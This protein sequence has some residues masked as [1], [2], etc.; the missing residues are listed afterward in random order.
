AAA[1]AE[2]PAA[3]EAN[4]YYSEARDRTDITVAL[5]FSG[6]SRS[7]K[8]NEN[9]DS[10]NAVTGNTGGFVPGLALE[11]E[12]YPLG[13]LDVG[14]WWLQL[15]GVHV[16]A[17]WTAAISWQ[18]NGQEYENSFSELKLGAS[19]RFV[20]WDDKAAPHA[21]LRLGYAMLSYPNGSSFPGAQYNAPY[22]ELDS[23]Y[24]L[25]F[26]LPL[27][28][29]LSVQAGLS[30]YLLSTPAGGVSNLGQ[31]Q[32]GSALG[33]N[34]GLVAA[35]DQFFVKAEATL[36]TISLGYQ[37]PFTAQSGQI[38]QNPEFSELSMG[39]KVLVG[40]TF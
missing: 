9:G 1:P 38:Y 25:P 15:A 7:A 33:V 4:T 3:E 34:L 28:D 20:L 13:Y 30:Y 8:L 27:I 14:P 5:G 21:T 17:L 18:D 11:I 35:L 37:G 23:E 26:E 6:L 12:A 36:Q 2:A 10:V 24:A 16:E 39:S 31:K 32:S 22:I 29:S 19:Y 40:I